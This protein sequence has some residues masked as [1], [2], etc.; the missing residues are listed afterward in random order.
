M[1]DLG[2]ANRDQMV[3]AGLGPE[4][5]APPGHCTSCRPDLFFSYRRGGRG[6]LVTVAAMPSGGA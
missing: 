6:R 2:A 5:V 1:L 4:H 3:A